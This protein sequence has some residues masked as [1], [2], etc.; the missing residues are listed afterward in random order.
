MASV[1][2]TIL[3]DTQITSLMYALCIILLLFYRDNIVII[4]YGFVGKYIPQVERNIFS[5]RHTY[6]H[7]YMLRACYIQYLLERI[8]ALVV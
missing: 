1:A 8:L 2:G 7:V 4:L 3:S 6:A 5:V